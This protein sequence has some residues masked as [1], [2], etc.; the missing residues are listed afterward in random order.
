MYIFFLIYQ[1][2]TQHLFYF[3]LLFA[4]LSHKPGTAYRPVCLTPLPLSMIMIPVMCTMT[5]L[6]AKD[7]LCDRETTTFFLT[8]RYLTV[9][10]RID[11]CVTG[12]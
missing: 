7:S 6:A 3:L 8:F 4:K 1:A 11:T 12:K 9:V 10:F 2:E 5:T